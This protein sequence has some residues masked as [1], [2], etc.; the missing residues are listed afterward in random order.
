MRWISR[1][2]SV[3]TALVV[4]GCS[5]DPAGPEG[6]APTLPSVESMTFD[7]EHFTGG[8]APAATVERQTTPGLHW[9][10]AALGVGLANAAVVVHLAVPVATWRAAA[11][12]TP[13]F[14]DGR[15][16]WRFSVQEGPNTYGGDLS[17]YADGGDAVFEMRVTATPLGLD[18]FLWY[19]GRAQVLGTTGSWSFYD[20]S[21]PSTVVGRIDWEHP[22]ADEWTVAFVAT[23]GPNV[24]DELT[25]TVDG[26]SRSVTFFDASA[27]ETVEVHWDEDT[28]EG[29]IVAPNYNGGVKACWNGLLQNT[30]CP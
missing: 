2:V 8:G 11:A 24:D 3:V 25:Y 18:D 30:T 22:Q 28:L 20:P 17:G 1:G 10:A 15:W 21:D 29:W 12:Q 19:T 6:A 23:D 26:T 14:E 5:D 9:A 13:V 27:G 4:V 16:H 7:F